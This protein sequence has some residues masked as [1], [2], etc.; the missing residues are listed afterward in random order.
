MPTAASPRATAARVIAQPVAR[1]RVSE[2]SLVAPAGAGVLVTGSHRSGTTWVGQIL[3]LAPGLCYLHEPFKPCWDP[4]RHSP[5]N[6]LESRFG[7]EK[8]NRKELS[9]VVNR[10]RK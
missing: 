10:D 8:T 6:S 5:M 2:E 4:P 3:G 1:E 7:F 9:A